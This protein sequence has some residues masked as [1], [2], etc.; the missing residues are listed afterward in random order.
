MTIIIPYKEDIL[1]GTE[2]R[3]AL[4]SIDKYL[5]GFTN[6]I[7]IGTP[8]HWYSGERVWAKD[9]DN[10]KQ[11]SIYSKLLIACELNNVTDSFVMWNDDHYLLQ[12]FSVNSILAWYDGY[13]KDTINKNHGLR[14]KETIKNTLDI[15]PNALNYDIHTPCIYNKNGIK[16]LF[17][18]KHSD[19]CIKSYYF[20]HI[21]TRSEE[22]KDFKINSL[23]SKD[24]I[25][26]LIKDRLFFSTSTNGMKKPMIEFMN[27][28]Y[29]NKSQWE[30]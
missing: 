5:T 16:L 25:K 10:K 17:I 26:E 8:P 30:K 4:R 7:I 19:I 22:M 2:L 18:N 14:Y 12:P 29:P 27:E 13:L 15:L 20:D 23:L 6:L 11:F 21:I 9:Y 24:A 3:F 28:L 1:S